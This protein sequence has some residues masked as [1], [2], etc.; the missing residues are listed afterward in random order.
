VRLRRDSSGKRVGALVGSSVVDVSSG[1]VR[2][3]VPGWVIKALVT[4]DTAGDR[5]VRTRRGVAYD[6]TNFT[7]RDG[8]VITWK[9]PVPTI[10]EPNRFTR[11][12]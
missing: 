4:W 7:V 9:Q 5:G 10:V 11:R 6:L 1:A 12:S 2:P 8:I 3:F